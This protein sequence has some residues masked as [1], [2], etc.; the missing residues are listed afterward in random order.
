[1][2]NLHQ[3]T[4]SINFGLYRY[5]RSLEIDFVEKSLV[6]NE[7]YHNNFKALLFLLP[8]SDKD[9]ANIRENTFPLYIFRL[10]FQQRLNE[11]ANLKSY[12]WFMVR[13][14]IH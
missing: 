9:D 7:V 13:K 11:L 14:W 2:H 12:E 1:M 4:W 10:F 5:I 3:C 6:G 8:F